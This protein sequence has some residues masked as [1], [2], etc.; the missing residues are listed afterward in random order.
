[1][2]FLGID[3]GAKRVG[4][5]ISDENGAFAFPLLVLQNS[6][7]L[8]E[9]INEICKENSVSEIVVGQSLN[10]CQEENEIMKEINVFVKNLEKSGLPVHLHPEF[11]TSVEAE[12][13]QGKNDMHDA[14]AAALIL[15]N[16]IDTYARK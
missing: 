4:V 10:F 7:K 15:K 5:A 8:I 14:S 2:R 16:Y 6:E 3:Y 13:L 9:E 1:M 11:L 12:R